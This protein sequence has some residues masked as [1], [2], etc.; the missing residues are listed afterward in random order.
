MAGKPLGRWKCSDQMG[1]RS[2]PARDRRSRDQTE[3]EGESGELLCRIT[4]SRDGDFTGHDG[5]GRVLRVSRGEDGAIE[6]RRAAET[7]DAADPDIVGQFPGLGGDPAR[8][9][10]GSTGD[11]M[12]RFARTQR[13]EDH[14]PALAEYQ[15]KLDRHYN[16]GR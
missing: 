10:K 12:S 7:G 15:R 4:E 13:G 9:A 14:M 2:A 5:E 1:V 16:N 11:A 6:V 8:A 3:E